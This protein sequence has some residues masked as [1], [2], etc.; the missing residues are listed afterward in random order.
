[1]VIKPYTLPVF[2]EFLGSKNP[3]SYWEEEALG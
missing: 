3:G 1:M 2:L